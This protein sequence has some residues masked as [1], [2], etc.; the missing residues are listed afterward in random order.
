MGNSSET[1]LHEANTYR[2][3]L[4]TQTNETSQIARHTRFGL[5]TFSVPN[6][7]MNVTKKM[8]STHR[9]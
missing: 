9:R 7:I 1:P 2:V 5:M 6:G 3:F 8:H 4:H